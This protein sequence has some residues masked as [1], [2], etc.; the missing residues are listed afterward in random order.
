M[1]IWERASSSFVLEF[2]KYSFMQSCAS[3]DIR[4]HWFHSVIQSQ[5]L[6]NF[7]LLE[8]GL[9]GLKRITVAVCQFC[10]YLFWSQCGKNIDYAGHS[11]S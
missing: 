9:Y 3:K 4:L 11:G 10:S 6:E 5:E 7:L 2:V 8:H 1:A